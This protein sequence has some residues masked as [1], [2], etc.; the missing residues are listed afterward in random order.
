VVFHL[1]AGMPYALQAAGEQIPV[2]R[3]LGIHLQAD[4]E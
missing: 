3:I 4:E 1:C 2:A